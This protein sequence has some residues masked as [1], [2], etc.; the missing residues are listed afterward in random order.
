VFSRYWGL[1]I[2]DRDRVEVKGPG[3]ST[4]GRKARCSAR[5][6]LVLWEL[7]A[8][9]ERRPQQQLVCCTAGDENWG[10]DLEEKQKSG[11]LKITYL[12]P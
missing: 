10:F 1:T 6:C 2:R 11:G 7:G 8:E 3:T 9:R 5:I 4:E 12:L